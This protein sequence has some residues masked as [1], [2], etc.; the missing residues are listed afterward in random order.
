MQI[1][2]LVRGLPVRLAAFLLTAAAVVFSITPQADAITRTTFSEGN[3]GPSPP[4]IPFPGQN[5]NSDLPN[6]FSV[7]VGPFGVD[8]EFLV[9]GLTSSG[10]DDSFQFSF[11]PG[12]GGLF[13][14]IAEEPSLGYIFTLSEVGGNN[15]N[16]SINA[17]NAGPGGALFDDIPFGTYNFFLDGQGGSGIQYHILFTPTADS[18]S[19]VPGSGVA[20]LT[21][22]AMFW[23]AFMGWRRRAAA[24]P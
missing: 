7:V 14:V 20:P 24:A 15:L 23:M 12:G 1:F 8:D 4:A 21:A 13:D 16:L 9:Q 3:V 11:S 5:L 2:L 17:A 19:A 18:T 6:D 22:A 10:G